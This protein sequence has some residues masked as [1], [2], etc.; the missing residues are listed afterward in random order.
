MAYVGRL[1][2]SKTVSDCF[3]TQ[4]FRFASGRQEQPE[5]ACSSY[6]LRQRFVASGGDIQELIV[7]LTQTDDFT[8]RRVALP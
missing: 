1:A 2:Q 4:F 5:D 3:T 7:G 8:M 6:R